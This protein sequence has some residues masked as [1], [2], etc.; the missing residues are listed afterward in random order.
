MILGGQDTS[1]SGYAKGPEEW[2]SLLDRPDSQW[3][4]GYSAYSLAHCWH[5]T[6]G[7]PESVRHAFTTSLIDPDLRNPI[8]L[9]A[10]PEFKVGM[11]GGGRSQSDLLVLA[12]AKND[13]VA[14]VVEGKV[15][16]SFG[17]KVRMWMQRPT[18][19]KV[20]RLKYLCQELGLDYDVIRVSDYRYQFFH[21]TVSALILAREFC[22]RWA[23]ML[24]QSF[25]PGNTGF[26]DCATFAEL[27]GIRAEVG[28]MSPVPGRSRPNLFIGWVNSPAP[29][30]K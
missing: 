10:I 11:P 12:R 14:I 5:E 23:V 25:D 26:Q 29:G 3:K 18:K 22:A 17:P 15:A 24:V 1:A 4:P 13:L 20:I 21:R 7:F 16:E 2:N 9:L 19:G 6:S 30:G 27:L 8:P 28:D